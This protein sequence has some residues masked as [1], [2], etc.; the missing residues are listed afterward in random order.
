MD[1]G[2]SKL[3][4]PLSVTSV[5]DNT[6]KGINQPTE[7]FASSVAVQNVEVINSSDG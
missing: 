6:R 3:F 7:E 2:L 1:D 4:S 5:T